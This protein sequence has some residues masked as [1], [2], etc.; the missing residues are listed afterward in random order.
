MFAIYSNFYN[1]FK[2]LLQFMKIEKDIS[3]SAAG[4]V[5]NWGYFISKE[6]GFKNWNDLNTTSSKVL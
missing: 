3:T 1:H 6:N 4:K 2:T 5:V